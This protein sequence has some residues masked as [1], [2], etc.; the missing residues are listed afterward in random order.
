MEIVIFTVR[1]NN[2]N[3]EFMKFIFSFGKGDVTYRWYL[4]N[5][6]AG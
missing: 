3:Q 4:L 1:S 6:V 5:L 2:L